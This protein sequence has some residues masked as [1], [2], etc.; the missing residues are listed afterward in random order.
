MKKLLFAIFLL[1]IFSCKNDH[2]KIEGRWNTVR[3]SMYGETIYPKDD[4]MI[5]HSN[6]VW[7]DYWYYEFD[8]KEEHDTGSWIIDESLSKITLYDG[9]QTYEGEY[10][11]KD[12]R[13]EIEGIIDQEYDEPFEFKLEKSN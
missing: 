13:L 9:V 3:Y 2:E 8:D 10:V 1:S 4:Y 6:G 12:N 11:L 7:E 5:F